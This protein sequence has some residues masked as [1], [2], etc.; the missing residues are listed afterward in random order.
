MNN[1]LLFQIPSW[2]MTIIYIVIVIALIAGLSKTV[3]GWVFIAPSKSG[4]VEKKW[5]LGAD[6]P[7]GRIIATNGEAGLQA[8]LLAPGLSWFKW[9]WMYSIKEIDPI[10]V[11]SGKIAVIK[12]QNGEQIESGLILAKTV[13]ECDNF[14]NAKL[15]LEGNGVMGIQRQFLRNGIYRINTAL[16]EVSLHEAIN[17]PEGSI[18]IVTVLDG[19]PIPTGEIASRA[20]VDH[21]KFQDADMF[22][23]ANGERGLQEEILSPGEYFINPYFAKVEIQDQVMVPIGTVGVVTSY[24]GDAPVDT[25]GSEFKHGIIVTNGQKGVQQNPLNPGMYPTNL[26]VSVVE[27]VPT[28]NIVL[29]WANAKT[30]AHELDSHL[31]TITARTK[32]GFPINLDVSQIINIA[33]DEAPK[34][35]ARFGTLKNLI[36]QVLE[37]TIGNYFRNAVQS[38]EALEFIT[39]RKEMQEEAK[40]FIASVLSQYNVVGVDTLIGDIIPPEALMAPIRERHVAIQQTAMYQ[41]QQKKEVARKDLEVASADADMQKEVIKAQQEV[42]ISE[43]HAE[44]VVKKQ[45]GDSEAIELKAKAEAE[46]T[47]VTAIAEAEAKEKIGKAEAEVILAKGKATATAYKEQTEAMGKENF[48]A[49]QIMSSLSESGMPIVPQ[50]VSG[51][52]GDGNIGSLVGITILEKLGAFPKNAENPV[53]PNNKK[54]EEDK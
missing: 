11:P 29:N 36:S 51:G 17:I 48:T 38:N 40:K 7:I 25:T 2:G 34:V 33:H 27:T 23:N 47:K 46:A 8:E 6:L 20:K 53:I 39:K 54:E 32:D 24:I 26:R 12:S 44:S 28:T 49:M 42:V 35:I 13:A 9:W 1:I 10:E 31:S 21:K 41:E 4:L 19:K 14:Q 3:L 15:F 52:S 16:F 45:K 5:S 22:L 50:I 18:G 43:R 30:E 37:P